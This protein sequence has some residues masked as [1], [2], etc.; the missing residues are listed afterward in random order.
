MQNIGFLFYMIL[1]QF[2]FVL[3]H[4]AFQTCRKKADCF[5]KLSQKLSKYLYFNGVLRFQMEVFLEVSIYSALNLY[6]HEFNAQLA[7]EVAS[8]VFSC[9]L[10]VVLSLAS[11]YLL[12]VTCARPSRLGSEKFKSK[13]G[14]PFEGI[15][16]K[17]MKEANRA[18][19]FWPAM[20]FFRRAAF[21]I[22][23][24]VFRGTLIAQLAIQ[25]FISLALCIYLQWYEPMDSKLATNLETFNELTVLIMTYFLFC[26]NDFVPDANTRSQL[27][28]YYTSVTLFNVTVHLIIMLASSLQSI[29][30][31]C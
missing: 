20:F 30:R 5:D 29:K 3:L 14:A 23:I 17:K 18:L 4:L 25:N 21:L 15:D 13:C 31:A 7:I 19:I 11:L 10:L 2:L 24:L 1:A 12:L 27:G 6:V 9:L 26:F 16:L 22:A 8:I 28:H